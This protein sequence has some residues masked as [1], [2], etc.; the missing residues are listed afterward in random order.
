MNFLLP[1]AILSLMVPVR[2]ETGLAL[3]RP[4]E[5]L[6]VLMLFVGLSRWRGLRVPHGLMLLVPALSLHVVLAG[7]GG[8]SVILREALQVG[9]VAIFA[10]ILAQEAPRLDMQ[11]LMRGL[12]WG[13]LAIIAYTIIWHLINGYW[14]GWK[15]LNDT[16]FAF[17]FLP[18]LLAGFILFA[19]PEKRLRLW[20]AWAG[21]AAIL[22]MS[23]ER[24]AL[25][26]YLFL[27]A[28][29][30]A[31]GR[32]ALILPAAV[33]GFAG[34]FALSTVIDNPYL[35]QQIRTLVDPTSTGNYE[36]VLITGQY[37]PDDT[38]SNAQRAFAY[39]LSGKFFKE[40]P[41]LGVGTNQYTAIL[42]QM[43]PTLPD[44]MKLGIHGEFQRTLTENGL[45]GLGFY[46]LIWAV[47]WLRFSRMLHH[48]V[49]LGRLSI[50]QARVVPPLIFVPMA[51]FLGTEAPGTR[52]FVGIIL[53]SLL[54]ELARGVLFCITVPAQR[55]ITWRCPSG[56]NVTERIA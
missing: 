50:S 45:L 14:V 15:R 11:R 31:R 21:L 30:L 51:L 5:G 32:L 10:F 19:R 55:K 46:L 37:A 20:M 35:Q 6:V 44:T 18:P 3:M 25:V 2:L 47:A 27:T 38:P 12:L 43:F 26:I 53:I 1:L 22:L 13:M 56:Y 23:G 16:K 52:A 34:L 24:K 9:A 54:P 48:A 39:A 28:L 40:H 49:R 7:A 29:L 36:Y 42:D 4:F 17:V 41:I 8:A 33:A